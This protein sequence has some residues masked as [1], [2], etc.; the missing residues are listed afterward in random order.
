MAGIRHTKDKTGKPHPKWRY[1]YVDWSGKRVWKTGSTDADRTLRIA[2]SYEDE[3]TRIREDVE[4]GRRDPPTSAEQAKPR[5]FEEL[6]TEYLEWGR[7]CGGKRGGPWSETHASMRERHLKF[8]R[9]QLG[10]K[11][12]ADLTNIQARVEKVLRNLNAKQRKKDAPIMA[13]S[14]KTKQNYVE[15]LAAFCDWCID[16]GFLDN[17]PLKNFAAFDCTPK[18]TRRRMT[19]EEVHLLLQSCKPHRRMFYEVAFGTGLRANELRS[20]RSSH[21]DVQRGGLILEA[22]WTKN[23]KAGFHPMSAELVAQLQ[24]AI[25]DNLA[26]EVYRRFQLKTKHERPDDVL[27]YV[28]TNTSRDF[29]KDIAAAGIQKWAPGGKVDFHAA[30]VTYISMVLDSGASVKEAQE[31]ARHSDP[32]LTMNIYG[33]AQAS[34]L[35][36]LANAVGRMT[37]PAQNCAMDVQRTAD[38]STAAVITSTAASVSVNENKWRR[39]ESNPRPKALPTGLLRV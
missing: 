4:L 14:G 38:G 20:L 10:L 17:D 35:S 29:D 5:S 15:A 28:P 18:T 36:A 37:S 32:R 6:T 9:D 34:N 8:W 19:A 33:R 12:L 21:L 23:R 24:Q 31:L 7:D 27:L 39:R 16:R 26:H 25:K 13:A 22:A 2:E 1:W 30:R 3:H 11:V